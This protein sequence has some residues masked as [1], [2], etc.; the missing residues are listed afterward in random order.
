[1]RGA[2]SSLRRS[3]TTK[4]AASLLHDIQVRLMATR[5]PD[6]SPPEFS[7]PTA[8][9]SELARFRPRGNP[10]ARA[11]EQGKGQPNAIPPLLG[12]GPLL[13]HAVQLRPGRVRLWRRADPRSGSRVSPCLAGFEC[14]L[15]SPCGTDMSKTSR[16]AARTAHNGPF[17][18]PPSVFA[19]FSPFPPPELEIRRN[20]LPPDLRRE[21]K[22]FAVPLTAAALVA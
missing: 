11:V 14:L 5:R 16:E 6:T 15:T 9:R 12:G 19:V 21:R 3:R 1:M 10:S 7:Q 18:A 4:I 17:S 2:C 22:T 8:L 13:P 20:L